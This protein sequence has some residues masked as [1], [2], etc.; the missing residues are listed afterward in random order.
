MGDKIWPIKKIEIKK[1]LGNLIYKGWK[2][3]VWLLAAVA[4]VQS[5]PASQNLKVVPD[6]MNVNDANNFRD[7]SNTAR[8]CKAT[9][10]DTF[11][12]PTKM[13]YT[14]QIPKNENDDGF[15][16]NDCATNKQSET[17]K[18]NM[19]IANTWKADRQPL[20]SAILKELMNLNA[21]LKTTNAAID[22]KF[23]KLMKE[24]NLNREQEALTRK[25]MKSTKQLIKLRAKANI[26]KRYNGE[27]CG[28]QFAVTVLN[29]VDEIIHG[30]SK[31]KKIQMLALSRSIPKKLPNGAIVDMVTSDHVCSLLD[32]PIED[33]TIKYDAKDKSIAQKVTDLLQSLVGKVC[34]GWNN[35]YADY[36]NHPN[37]LYT[38]K[39][40]FWNGVELET[41]IIPD[42]VEIN[43]L[44]E[45]IKNTIH[46]YLQPLGFDLAKGNNHSKAMS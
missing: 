46:S 40:K 44:P 38:N 28:G 9:Y 18:R 35:E 42:P 10:G 7:S 3:F 11:N 13:L 32:D 26:A 17:C 45:K 4:G 24:E 8:I 5:L 27:N 12:K 30:R 43:S 23:E 19:G 21:E 36:S 2:G 20:Q 31:V 15:I 41:V 16:P 33:K 29:L 25:Y 14:T 6:N 39:N 34:D 37:V 1:M 22:A